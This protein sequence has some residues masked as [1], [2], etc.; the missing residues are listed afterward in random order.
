MSTQFK[1]PT[2]RTDAQ[3]YDMDILDDA[4][5]VK[6]NYPDG[7]G[8][9]VSADFARELEC[10]LS[11]LWRPIETAL[12]DAVEI[13]AWVKGRGR[14][15]GVIWSGGTWKEYWQDEYGT[16]SW[17]PMAPYVPTHWMPIPKGPTEESK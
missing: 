1:I 10:D 14:V 3:T 7:L 5:I 15:A 2:P 17:I 8:D 16:M 9:H 13:D 11:R 6:V 12:K 4:R